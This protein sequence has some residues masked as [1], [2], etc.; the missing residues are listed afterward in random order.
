MNATATQSHHA[1]TAWIVSAAAVVVVAA[2]VAQS[3]LLLLILLLLSLLFRTIDTE[4]STTT[5]GVD[6]SD[7]A[8]NPLKEGILKAQRR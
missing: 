1:V 8:G 7:S 4:P 5:V 6:V 3:S 2:G